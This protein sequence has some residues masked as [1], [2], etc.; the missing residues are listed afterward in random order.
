VSNLNQENPRFRATGEMAALSAATILEAA[1]PSPAE[2]SRSEA[3]KLFI[4]RMAAAEELA[5]TSPALYQLKIVSWAVLGYSFMIVMPIILFSLILVLIFFAV[6]FHLGVYAIKPLGLAVIAMLAAIGCYFKALF[7]PFPETEGIEIKAADYPDLF[8]QVRELASQV[9]VKIDRIYLDYQINAAVV[10][11]P[12]YGLLGFYE[13][14]LI[15]GLPLMM[16][17]TPDE[18]RSVIAHEFGHLAGEHSRK[19]GWI[20][21]MIGRW[22]SIL[23]ALSA[24]DSL[25][26]SINLRF[27][28]W[29]YPYFQALASIVTRQHEREADRLAVSIAGADSHARS[30]LQIIVRSD[31]LSNYDTRELLRQY[32]YE[33]PVP[34]DFY[35]RLQE[36]MRA[37][38]RD[39]IAAIDSVEADLLSIPSPY[40]SHPPH[41]ERIACCQKVSTLDN[42]LPRLK[43]EKLI[44]RFG[45]MDPVK[46]TAIESF[47]G[48]QYEKLMEF[49]CQ[50]FVKVNE[51]N[52]KE[53]SKNFKQM[54]E[55]NAELEKKRSEGQTLTAEEEL[56]MVVNVHLLKGVFEAAPLYEELHERYPDNLEVSYQLAVH[57]Y[58]EMHDKDRGRQLLEVVARGG[59]QFRS[60]ACAL[61][62]SHFNKANDHAKYQ[63][64]E[65]LY[66]KYAEEDYFYQAE[67]NQVSGADKFKAH[68]ASSEEVEKIRAA[69]ALQPSVKAAYLI[70]KELKISPEDRLFVLVV[71]LKVDPEGFGGDSN[72]TVAQATFNSLCTAVPFPAGGYIYIISSGSDALLKVV[73]SIDNALILGR[74]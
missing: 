20:Y 22:Q 7:V 25:L 61:L 26:L 74:S 52:W 48:A 1:G 37:P 6:K 40:D 43:A 35:R 39:K 9:G 32:P 49:C 41:A 8:R 53:R 72:L 28:S 59:K 71:R 45:L 2:A 38:I 33:G 64:F 65:K 58:Y 14:H 5:K 36:H 44:D 50:D 4:K 29:F 15:L 46:E 12:R 11:R 31:R 47:F 62:M 70:E 69:V 10:E 27:F 42:L 56:E 21:K 24:S 55:R 68:S 18:F 17:L 73:K 23:Q 67:R 3:E 60:E 19:T 66:N 57:N 54:E 16:I 51:E 34:N 30:F 63:E 13:N